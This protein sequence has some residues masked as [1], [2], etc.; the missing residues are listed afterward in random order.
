M[1]HHVICATLEMVQLHLRVSATVV[2]NASVQQADT[3]YSP[4]RHEDVPT[5]TAG[6]HVPCV[7]ALR[8]RCTC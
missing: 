4:D 3:F 5:C 2:C 8:S 6:S 1:L 7:A